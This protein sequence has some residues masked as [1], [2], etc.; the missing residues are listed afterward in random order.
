MA[1]KQL[2]LAAL[3]H[4]EIGTLSLINSLKHAEF[5]A[6]ARSADLGLGGVG[7]GWFVCR[8]AVLFV[9]TG[10]GMGGNLEGDG[11]YCVLGIAYC[12]RSS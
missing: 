12:G 10:L 3:F 8:V 2:F 1:K 9:L 6:L 11:S 5:L 7:G 4:I